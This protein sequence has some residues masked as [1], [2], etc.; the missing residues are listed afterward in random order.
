M[1]SYAKSVKLVVTLKA[2]GSGEIYPP[3]IDITYG[4]VTSD[5]YNTGA[6]VEVHSIALLNNPTLTLRCLYDYC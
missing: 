3:Y 5:S 6:L 1:I 4:Q 2:D